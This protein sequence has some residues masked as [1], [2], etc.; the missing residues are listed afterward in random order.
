M[1]NANLRFACRQTDKRRPKTCRLVVIYQYT[2][3][4]KVRLADLR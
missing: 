1:A 4:P 2:G 3:P